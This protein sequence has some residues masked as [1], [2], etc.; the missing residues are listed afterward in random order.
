MIHSEM[1]YIHSGINWRFNEILSRNG[2]TKHEECNIVVFIVSE[3]YTVRFQ[4]P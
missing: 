1:A 4:K 2:Y 3:V